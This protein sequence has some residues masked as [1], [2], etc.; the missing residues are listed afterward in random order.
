ML[1][2]P[3][4]AAGGVGQRLTGGELRRDHHAGRVETSQRQDAA[5]HHLRRLSGRGRRGGHARPHVDR[6]S[7]AERAMGGLVLVVEEQ[8]LLADWRVGQ[9]DA[10]GEAGLTVHAPT[11]RA[12]PLKRVIVELEQVGEGFVRQGADLEGHG[13]APLGSPALPARPTRRDPDRAVAHPHLQVG[14]Q[15]QVVGGGAGQAAVGGP[16]VQ[17][18][19]AR[20]GEQVVDP[21]HRQAGG[22]GGRGEGRQA[23]LQVAAGLGQAPVGGEARARVEVAQQQGRPSR[24]RGGPSTP[25]RA[26]RRPGASAR[27]ASALGGC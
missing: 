20:R 26:A 17:R 11:H 18:P 10:A 21:Q 3:Q 23:Q 5:A 14:D 22:V 8:H 24:R 16:D 2:S 25:A 12:Q 7:R 19:H 27:T 15:G 6:V 9:A 4:E 1:G 13:R